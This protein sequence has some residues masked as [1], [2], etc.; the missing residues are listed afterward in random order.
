MNILDKV[1]NALNERNLWKLKI[2][3]DTHSIVIE[4]GR[5]SLIWILKDILDW[6]NFRTDKELDLFEIVLD[7]EQGYISFFLKPENHA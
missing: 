5:N 6:D 1:F 7:L 3:K 4:G 2:I